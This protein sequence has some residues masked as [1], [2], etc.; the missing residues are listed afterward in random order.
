M[1]MCGWGQTDL[2]QFELSEDMDEEFYAGGG[3]FRSHES[4]HFPQLWCQTGHYSIYGQVGPS[5]NACKS[6]SHVRLTRLLSMLGCVLVLAG[7]LVFVLFFSVV[8]H[9]RWPIY[10]TA[11]EPSCWEASFQTVV[12][13]LCASV[14]IQDAH[15]LLYWLVG[16]CLLSRTLQRL[17]QGRLSIAQLAWLISVHV[18]WWSAGIFY[19]PIPGAAPD[20]ASGGAPGR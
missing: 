18:R 1:S 6:C 14:Y 9:A 12:H 17:C 8:Q 16:C 11:H 3:Q 20:R 4:E 2:Q 5:S 7:V 15:F 13:L 10:V 19:A